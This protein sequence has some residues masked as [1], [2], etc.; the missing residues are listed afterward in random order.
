MEGGGSGGWKATCGEPIG[1]IQEQNLNLLQ[2]PYTLS[3]V[4][5]LQSQDCWIEVPP[6]TGQAQRVMQAVLAW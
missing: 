4:S 1:Q 6:F 2:A 3:D 5:D